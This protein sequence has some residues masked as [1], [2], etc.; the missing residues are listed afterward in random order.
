VLVDPGE[1]L[2]GAEPWKAFLKEHGLQGGEIEVRQ[3]R[4]RV[5][6]RGHY[7]LSSL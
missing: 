2:P 3:I 6:R 1:H 5:L 7:L 4:S